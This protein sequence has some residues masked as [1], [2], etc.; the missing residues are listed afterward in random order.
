MGGP[1]PAV[2]ATPHAVSVWSA[3]AG[4]VGSRSTS[5]LSKAAGGPK[6][7][8]KQQSL[9]ACVRGHAAPELGD[10]SNLIV[11]EI[12]L[13]QGSEQGACTREENR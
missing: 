7:A 9:Q 3:A 5:I 12:Q 13:L 6:A 4:V 8:E 10:V 11:I 1:A 2:A